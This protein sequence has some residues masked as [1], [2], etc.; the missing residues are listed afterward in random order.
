[1]GP[2]VTGPRHGEVVTGTTTISCQAC[3]PCATD[4]RNLCTE[5]REIG[6]YGRTGAVAEYRPMPRHAQ[7][8]DPAGRR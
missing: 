4:H 6:V 1:L 5:L 3:R 2:V 7:A 8:P